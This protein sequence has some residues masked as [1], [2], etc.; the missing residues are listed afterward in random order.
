MSTVDTSEKPENGARYHHGALETALIDAG[1]EELAEKG[2]EGF[3]LRAVAKRA[4]VSHAAPAHHFG[5][6]NGLLTAI[7]GHGYA[8]FNTMQDA[9]AAKAGRDPLDVLVACGLAYVDFADRHHAL[10]RLVFS[11]DRTDFTNPRLSTPS[12]DAFKALAERVAAASGQHPL[13]DGNYGDLALVWALSH[14]LADLLASGRL[15]A[16]STLPPAE[17][18][19]TLRRLL[20]R[21]WSVIK[22]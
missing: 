20:S 19:E 1:I 7:A 14:G 15:K 11:S 16:I 21:S 4:G 3:S 18:E 10:F 12:T 5:D 8:L 6:A 13:Q 2:I 9:Y 22:C 17:R